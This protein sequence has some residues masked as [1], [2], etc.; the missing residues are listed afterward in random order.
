[1]SWRDFA[2]YVMAPHPGRFLDGRDRSFEGGDDSPILRTIRHPLAREHT[3]DRQS[4]HDRQAV[5]VGHAG[6]HADAER[7]EAVSADFLFGA[8]RSAYRHDALP[9]PANRPASRPEDHT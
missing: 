3:I 1:M 4:L 7:V 9:A 5:Q 2:T 6:A 8:G